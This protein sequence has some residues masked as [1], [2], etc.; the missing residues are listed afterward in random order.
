MP[1]SVSPPGINPSQQTHPHTCPQ[2]LNAAITTPG[3]HHQTGTLGRREQS[4]DGSS[5]EALVLLSDCPFPPAWHLSWTPHPPGADLHPKS[6]LRCW[7]SC[8]P[9]PI[10]V[11]TSHRAAGP[12]GRAGRSR[13]CSRPPWGPAPLHPQIGFWDPGSTVCPHPQPF[14][15]RPFARHASE[16][17]ACPQSH[18]RPGG[19]ASGAAI[20]Q[21]ERGDVPQHIIQAMVSPGRATSH[22]GPQPTC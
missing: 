21:P 9:G 10:S 2:T 8:C 1:R 15:G 14:K 7:S 6:N 22:P 12:E 17:G 13:T 18:L 4:P 20:P 5:L 19:C 11:L 16:L 3:G